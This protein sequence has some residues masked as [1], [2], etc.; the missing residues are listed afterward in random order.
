M[1]DIKTV[2][3]I[4]N[5]SKLDLSDSELELMQK[6]LTNIIGFIEKIQKLDLKDVK[7]TSHTLE[8]HNNIF[9][10]DKN[11]EFDIKHFFGH[12]KNNVNGYITTKKVLEY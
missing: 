4:A 10:S 9:Q 12:N 6:Q 1:L 7:P 3:H 2:K 5:L 11:V 8:N